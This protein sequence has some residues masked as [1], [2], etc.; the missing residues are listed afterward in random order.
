MEETVSCCNVR[1]KSARSACMM[2]SPQGQGD[3]AGG[4]GGRLPERPPGPDRPPTR[5]EIDRGREAFYQ[6]RAESQGGGE[7]TRTWM[8]LADEERL[9]W[10]RRPYL[11]WPR[12]RG[13]NGETIEEHSGQPDNPLTDDKP[14]GSTKGKKD[15]KKQVKPTFEYPAPNTVD[16]IDAI[17]QRMDK[18]AEVTRTIAGLGLEG[19]GTEVQITELQEISGR[20]ERLARELALRAIAQGTMSQA[21]VARG[22][23]ISQATVSRLVNEVAQG[24]EE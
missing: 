20:T 19:V 12:Y 13:L 22:L 3:A 4:G 6:W 14:S 11:E 8:D 18:L 10:I 15:G 9:E 24:Q 23:G 7:I 17:K 2:H 16:E 5:E 1:V 21:E